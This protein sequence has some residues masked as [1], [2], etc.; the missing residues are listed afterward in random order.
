MS[1][2]PDGGASRTRADKTKSGEMPQPVRK[3]APTGPRDDF[4]PPGRSN[5]KTLHRPLRKREQAHAQATRK[6]LGFGGL[7]HRDGGSR[8]TA[9]PRRGFTDLDALPG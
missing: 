5:S 2:R 9:G 6:D 7:A 4:G 8:G 3:R 1:R